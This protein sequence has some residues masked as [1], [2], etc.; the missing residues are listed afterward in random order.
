MQEAIPNSETLNLVNPSR[1]HA[2]YPGFT[3]GLQN[4]G[5]SY[6]RPEQ[7]KTSK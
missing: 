6:A 1:V 3:C 7:A 4:R 5:I 2:P